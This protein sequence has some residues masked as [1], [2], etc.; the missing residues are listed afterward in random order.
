MD[1]FI[2]ALQYCIHFIVDLRD[3]EAEHI[4]TQVSVAC[5]DWRRHPYNVHTHRRKRH[6]EI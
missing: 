6:A 4:D 2:H 1:F 3:I 5:I